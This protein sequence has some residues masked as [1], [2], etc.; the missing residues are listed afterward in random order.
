MT[1]TAQV[2]GLVI[3][4]LTTH[5]LPEPASLLVVNAT[6]RYEVKVQAR[7]V[8][9]AETAAVL[10]SWA[11]STRAAAVAHAWRPNE[12]TVHLDVRTTLA[13]TGGAV[14]L[15]IYGGVAFD[16]VTFADLEIDG[17]RSITLA[18]LLAWATSRS[19]VAA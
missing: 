14:P 19:G 5:G 16:P 13:G 1:T 6:I 4:H 15:I 7:G 3:E 8:G 9:L 10:V 18:Q 2:V 12:G 11:N 17:R